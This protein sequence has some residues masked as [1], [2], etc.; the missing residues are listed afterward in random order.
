MLPI[1][2]T[3][4]YLEAAVK[5]VDEVFPQDLDAIW[6]PEKSLPLSLRPQSELKQD[7][8]V[9]YWIVLNDNDEIIGV[10]GMY[11]LKEDPEDV[12]W[13]G[14]Y[15]IRA[16]QR[17]RGLGRELLNWTIDKAKERG[18]KKM[19]LY[20]ST[21]PNEAAAQILYDKLDFKIIGEDEGDGIHK[22]LYRQKLL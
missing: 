15:C 10:T 14:W 8:F 18:F 17:G 6:N 5:M 22:T 12:V 16:D 21:D 11:R 2:L 1:P 9:D 20:T 7:V 19:K 4:K 3:E 13:L